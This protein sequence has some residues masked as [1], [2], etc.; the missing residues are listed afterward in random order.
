MNI[1]TAFQRNLR[2]GLAGCLN[3]GLLAAD[4]SI[5][6]LTKDFDVG[7]RTAMF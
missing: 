4:R 2:M 7:P 3:I 6:E 5:G 1:L